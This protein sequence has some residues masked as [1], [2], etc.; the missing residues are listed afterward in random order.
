M[1]ATK[2]TNLLLITSV[3][4]FSYELRHLNPTPQS[5]E[6]ISTTTVYLFASTPSKGISVRR[7]RT[8][9]ATQRNPSTENVKEDGGC[10]LF[11]PFAYQKLPPKPP[12]FIRSSHLFL[13]CWSTT[14]YLI[15]H[16][17]PETTTYL[18]LQV[19]TEIRVFKA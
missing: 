19:A 2:K 15:R 10:Y 6:I 7:K 17:L 5:P 3:Y 1:R 8:V 11:A 13:Q 12:F 14:T 4:Q 9:V 18:E 16:L